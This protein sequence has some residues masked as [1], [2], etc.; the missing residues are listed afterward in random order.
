MDAKNGQQTGV[1]A[2]ASPN[3]PYS[4]PSFERRPSTWLQSPFCKWCRLPTLWRRTPINQSYRRVTRCLLRGFLWRPELCHSFMAQNL[5]SF[6]FVLFSSLNIF[7]SLSFSTFDTCPAFK[8]FY[9][10]I[11]F[12][13]IVDFIK[14][15]TILQSD[16]R[17]LL[18]SAIV[19]VFLKGDSLLAYIRAHT[20][21]AAGGDAAL[22][23]FTHTDTSCSMHMTCVV[24]RAKLIHQAERKRS[25]PVL[26]YGKVAVWESVI[27]K[28]E[29][30]APSCDVVLRMQ[31]R[32]TQKW[33][34]NCSRG[35]SF[36]ALLPL[37][38]D[39]CLTCC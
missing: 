29:K 16:T 7:L 30:E 22:N 33:S 32:M 21:I 20:R 26:C 15:S 27:I 18:N 35:P 5:R 1:P 17:L 8:S 39:V 9:Q 3:L 13:F 36:L 28:P 37:L 2:V 14:D 24:E 31:M 19:P 34:L 11:C 38:L 23:P 10:N 12:C 6:Y 25:H 4:R